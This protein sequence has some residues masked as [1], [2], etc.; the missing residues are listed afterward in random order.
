MILSPCWIK[1][2][3]GVCMQS[4]LER[5][6]LTVLCVPEVVMSQ[7]HKL[8]VNDRPGDKVEVSKKWKVSWQVRKKAGSIWKFF[9]R[10]GL[11]GDED[12]GTVANGKTKGIGLRLLERL[13]AGRPSRTWN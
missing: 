3:L 7:C 12:I 8:N 5:W 2:M 9:T 4:A 6:K 11:A 1:L 10:E 13:L